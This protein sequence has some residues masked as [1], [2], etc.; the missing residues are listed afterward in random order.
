MDKEPFDRIIYKVNLEET[1]APQTVQMPHHAEIR[2]IA[3][4]HQTITIWFEQYSPSP[5]EQREFLIV[6]T[7]QDFGGDLTYR[8]TVFRDPFVWHIYE[9]MAP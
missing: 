5:P 8:G 9:I 7:G 6:P 2:E 4:Q 1:F 3:L